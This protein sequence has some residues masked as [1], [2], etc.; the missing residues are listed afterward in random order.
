LLE[1]QSPRHLKPSNRLRPATLKAYVS[2]E[3]TPI[4]RIQEKIDLQKLSAKLSNR[5]AKEDLLDK[6]IIKQTTEVAHPSLHA[7]SANR[8]IAQKDRLKKALNRRSSVFDM[9]EKHEI[10]MFSVS[11]AY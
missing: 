1:I 8:A 11:L 6:N 7:T 9:A 4:H 5:P 10:R 2:P 3:G